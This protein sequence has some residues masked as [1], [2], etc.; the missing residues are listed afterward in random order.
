[1]YAY[2]FNNWFYNIFESFGYVIVERV[3]IGGTLQCFESVS[4][5]NMY[6]SNFIV[7]FAEHPKGN[8]TDEQIEVLENAMVVNVSEETSYG[9][10]TEDMRLK[11]EWR[12]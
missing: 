5:A 11:K 12:L 3:P 7:S 1:M 8:L 9:N 2:F 10:M 6:Q 4:S